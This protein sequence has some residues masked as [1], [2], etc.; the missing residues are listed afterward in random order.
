MSTRARLLRGWL[1][2]LEKDLKKSAARTALLLVLFVVGIYVWVPMLGSRP[3]ATGARLE[4]APSEATAEATSGPIASERQ[5]EDEL[6]D[7]ERLPEQVG[8]KPG[9]DPWILRELRVEAAPPAGAPAA[10][11]P[12]EPEARPAGPEFVLHSILV[13]GSRRVARLG[14][15]TVRVGDAV[16][17]FVVVRI[18]EGALVL[19]GKRSEHTLT[20][21]RRP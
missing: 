1:G 7:A 17:G 21:R 18:T 15:R 3:G 11:A 5:I 16:G 12:S 2:R 9:Q 8:L 20:L 19:R 6:R 14:S 10:S 13:A 4:A